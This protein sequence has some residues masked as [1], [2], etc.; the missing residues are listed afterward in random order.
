[1]AFDKSKLAL[2]AQGN[3]FGL[4]A[5]STTD[6]QATVNTAGYFNAAAGYLNVGDVIIANVDIASARA[7][8]MFWVNANAGGVVDV[9]DGLALGTTDTD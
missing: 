8:Y 3:G 2:L 9:T 1:M 7:V 6:T 4:W 5:Y